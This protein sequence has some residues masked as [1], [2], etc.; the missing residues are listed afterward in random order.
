MAGQIYIKVGSNWKQADN[1]YVNVNGTWRTGSEIEVN[2]AGTWG[3]G[4][5]PSSSGLPT[6]AQILGFDLIEFS[7][8]IPFIID[9]KAA[10]NSYGFDIIE[11][12]APIKG[13]RSG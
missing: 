6:R 4:A 11:F 12:A 2:V 3:G 1:Y 8:P 7:T 13:G 10:V 9:S 5:A